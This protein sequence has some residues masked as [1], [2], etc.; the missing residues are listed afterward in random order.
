MVILDL[1]HLEIFL[2]SLEMREKLFSLLMSLQE[3]QGVVPALKIARLTGFISSM[4]L[5]LG[6]VS[7]HEYRALSCCKAD[8][9]P[10]SWHETDTSRQKLEKRLHFNF[11]TV[12]ASIAKPFG[13][14]GCVKQTLD[15]KMPAPQVGVVHRRC[16]MRHCTR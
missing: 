6:P 2:K 3:T 4:W 13:K 8:V 16:Y 10:L 5:A 1:I 15:G 12:I 7:G 9:F 11:L 14:K